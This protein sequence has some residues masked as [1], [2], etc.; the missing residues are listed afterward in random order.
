MAGPDAFPLP[1]RG[2]CRCG[3]LSFQVT[4]PP[5]F[6]FACH[7]TDCRQHAA[8]AFS[9]GMAAEA[10]GFV[11]DGEPH[12]WERRG[13][14]RPTTLADHAWVRPVAQIF[15]RSALPWALMPT[16]LSYEAEFPDPGPLRLAF[17]VSGIRPG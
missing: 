15:T 16:L 13:S 14:V 2:A 12:V 6:T 9:L 5:L 3:R 10:A 8:S 7:C 4:R 17:A 11:L 1:M